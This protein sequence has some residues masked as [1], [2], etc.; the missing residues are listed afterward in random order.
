MWDL[1]GKNGP[2]RFPTQPLG[3]T[4]APAALNLLNG[5]NNVRS[6]RCTFILGDPTLRFAVVKPPGAPIPTAGGGGVLLNWTASGTTGAGYWVY[7]SSN[8]SSPV[9]TKLTTGAPLTATTYTSTTLSGTNRY[10]VRA[11]SI[12]ATGSGSYTN[13]SQGAFT[14]YP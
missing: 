12:Q 3:E 10:M 13:L 7:G 9:W 8:L 4:L 6:V 14:T 1:N 2:W 5:V 11:V